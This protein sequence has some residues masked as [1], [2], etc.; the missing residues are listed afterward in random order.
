MTSSA[1]PSGSGSA[2]CLQRLWLR[3]W[4]AARGRWRRARFAA[5]SGPEPLDP[6]VHLAL[7]G[8]RR[9]LHLHTGVESVSDSESGSPRILLASRL[10]EGADVRLCLQASRLLSRARRRPSHKQLVSSAASVSHKQAAS[11]CRLHR[12]LSPRCRRSSALLRDRDGLGGGRTGAGSCSSHLHS[13]GRPLRQRAGSLSVLP[14]G[15]AE[16]S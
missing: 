5:H 6:C 10:P 16:T 14:G 13:C 7:F 9:V 1:A 8:C 2:W 11:R 12:I 15:L 3:T 4:P